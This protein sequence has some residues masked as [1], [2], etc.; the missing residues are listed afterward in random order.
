MRYD[1]YWYRDQNYIRIQKSIS[2][3]ITCGWGQICV[4]ILSGCKNKS[5]KNASFIIGL[6]LLLDRTESQDNKNIVAR[7]GVA[8]WIFLFRRHSGFWTNNVLKGKS[9]VE[10]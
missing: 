4:N 1:K 8:S 6:Y 5:L 7:N 10:L 3:L 9:F 2:E